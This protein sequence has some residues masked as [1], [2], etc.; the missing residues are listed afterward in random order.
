MSFSFFDSKEEF[1]QTESKQYIIRQSKT[2][3]NELN[4]LLFIINKQDSI[5]VEKQQ[6]VNQFK[7]TRT[8]Y[9]KIEFIADYI[10]EEVFKI[11]II[12]DEKRQFS[13]EEFSIST[14]IEIEALLAEDT[15][16]KDELKLLIKK[17]QNQN[18][19]FYQYLIDETITNTTLFE[20]IKYNF[21]RIET[22][23]ITDFDC[24]TTLNS[25]QDIIAN[26][27]SID[28]IF[29]LIKAKQDIA[30]QQKIT[31]IQTKI[32]NAIAYLSIVDFNTI[33]R[34]QFT[35]QH[36]HTI[37]KDI[38]NLY[39]ILDVKYLEDI[40]KI[41]RVV[42]LKADNIYQQDFINTT[43]YSDDKYRNITTTEIELGKKLFFD[44]NLSNNREMSCASCHQ[45]NKFFTDGLTTAITN[46]A[47]DFQKRNT[48]TLLNSAL[49][50]NFFHDMRA[51]S[52]EQ[53]VAHVV[54]NVEEFNI[55]YDTIIS[56]LNSNKNYVTDFKSIYNY[57][58]AINAAT[59]NAA[60][61]AFQHSLISLNSEF[62]KFMRGEKKKLPKN[63]ENGYNLFMGKA[64]CGTCHF[65]P[66][67][68]GNVPPFFGEMES[69]VLSIPIVWDTLNYIVDTDLGRYKFLK[70][71]LFRNSFKTPTLRNIAHT[72][73]Y[74]H[75]GSFSS[76]ED[77]LDFYNRGGASAFGKMLPNQTMADKKLNL[78]NKEIND[79][80]SFMHTLTDSTHIHI[81]Q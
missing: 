2:L 8:Q 67:F 36:L 4:N 78:S 15:I 39:K 35:K 3:Q 52:F 42:Q 27:Q 75:N 22:L 61:A 60:I 71:D 41:K 10:A 9:K 58:Q 70:F 25:T 47:G 6:I 46:Q 11:P 55:S 29:S 81:K 38:T 51:K 76:L 28:T 20:A 18:L 56:R 54:N 49:Q 19:Q 64:K 74:M 1:L 21:I 7:L 50:N 32:N 31:T 68:Y 14:L 69:E 17:F 65:A 63:I 45:P 40:Y 53:Q 72:A 13:M 48:P 5:I 34:L 33:N 26:L 80:I 59:I 77:V 66:T 79:I 24:E 73:P 43:F 12:L 37:Y 62:D 30:I 44:K 23:N 16:N 57:E